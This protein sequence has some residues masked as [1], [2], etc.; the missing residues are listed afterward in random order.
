MR[1]DVGKVVF[2]ATAAVWLV[3]AS[4]VATMAQ[5]S[6]GTLAIVNG[7]PGKRVDVCLNGREIRSGLG[8][9]RVVSRDAAK[10]GRT[11]IRFYAPDPRRCRGDLVAQTTFALDPGE[12]LSVVLTRKAPRVVVFDNIGLGTI[13]PLGAPWED[14]DIG[15]GAYRSAADLAVNLRVRVWTPGDDTPVEGFPTAAQLW[16]KGYE[17]K[18]LYAADDIHRLRATLPGGSAAIAD[19]G[20]VLIRA[21]HRY[22]WILVGTKPGNARFVLLDRVTSQVPQ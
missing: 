13:P 15:L 5:D 16:T 18:D 2:G 8:Y 1:V 19:A 6:K 3:V 14:P 9:G 10:V 20:R 4:P 21:S 17:L 12:D 11:S 22:E 7:T